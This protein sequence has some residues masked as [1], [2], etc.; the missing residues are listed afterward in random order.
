V[1]LTYEDDQA[2]T[3]SLTEPGTN[4]QTIKGTA[5]TDGGDA[6]QVTLAVYAGSDTSGAPAKTLT[7][8]VAADGSFTGDVSG[9][10]QG[11]W[12]V[13]ASQFDAAG[14][15]GSSTGTTFVN[16]TT[17]PTPTLSAPAANTNDST[18]TISGT[19]GTATGDKSAVSVEIRN[20][21][22][23]VTTLSA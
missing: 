23:L 8:P 5:G 10:D 2:P 19:A 16:D 7:V 11:S 6:P 12:T 15:L 20:G 1:T 22:T 3:I 21:D 17:A 14:N 9:L 18:P 13:I 4:P